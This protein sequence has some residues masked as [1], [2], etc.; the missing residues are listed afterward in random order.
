MRLLKAQ[1]VCVCILIE[2]MLEDAGNRTRE[3]YGFEFSGTTTWLVY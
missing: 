2:S 3:C 1:S